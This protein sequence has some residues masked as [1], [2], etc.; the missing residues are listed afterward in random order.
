[1]SAEDR[2]DYDDRDDQ[3]EEYWREGT[4]DPECPGPDEGW[5]APQHLR[6]RHVGLEA[7]APF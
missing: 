1:M 3:W 5:E 2:R 7:E 4:N 6:N